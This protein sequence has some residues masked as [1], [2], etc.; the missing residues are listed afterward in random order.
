MLN[1]KT[2]YDPE[3]ALRAL[4]V[5]PAW[6]EADFVERRAF[7]LVAFAQFLVRARR[8]FPIAL[9]WYRM[10]LRQAAFSV[11]QALADGRGDGDG[12]G[13]EDENDTGPGANDAKT[14]MPFGGSLSIR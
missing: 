8:G 12:D 11:R 7:Q 1:V 4:A 5:E 9:R 3:A 2:A 6:D 14:K 13:P 10:A